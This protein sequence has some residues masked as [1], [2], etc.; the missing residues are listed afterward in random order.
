VRPSVL[1]IYGIDNY[2]DRSRLLDGQVGGLEDKS[3]LDGQAD[4]RAVNDEIEVR[5]FGAVA[6]V[7]VR[8]QRP[9]ADVGGARVD[10]SLGLGGAG[11]PSV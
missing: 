4:Q 1:A 11:K 10:C 5:L 9:V 2:L 3:K 8:R 6:E 7:D